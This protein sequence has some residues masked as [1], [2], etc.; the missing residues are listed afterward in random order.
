MKSVSLTVYQRSAKGRRAVKQ[1]RSAQRVPA[2]FYGRRTQ[3]Q[4]LEM[5][6]VDIERLIHHSASDNLL[7]DLAIAEESERRLALVQDIQHHPVTGKV[8]H[9]DFHEVAEDEKVT[10]EV[11]VETVGEAVGVKTGG[12][13]LEH[14]LFRIRVRA[15]PRDLP[16]VISVD[17]TNLQA[18][19]TIHVNQIT[20][21]AGVEVVGDKHAPVIAIAVPTVEASPKPGTAAEA[22]LEATEPAKAAAEKK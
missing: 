4:S 9:V 16:E 6:L 21:P 18:G 3:A 2:V 1:L 14:V 10:V 13:I 19:E 20:L 15:L 17:V 22:P 11:P 8:L 7:V 12:G 5:Q